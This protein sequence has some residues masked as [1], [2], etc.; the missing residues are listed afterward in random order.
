MH[1]NVTVQV[2]P[3]MVTRFFRESSE[4]AGFLVKDL[5][6]TESAA[7]GFIGR[8]VG[9]SVDRLTMFI[10]VLWADGASQMDWRKANDAVYQAFA[11]PDAD[12]AKFAHIVVNH[13]ARDL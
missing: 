2:R 9:F 11:A 6:D 10:T 3:N 8:S 4:E 1:A 5:E 12:Y 13:F 7:P